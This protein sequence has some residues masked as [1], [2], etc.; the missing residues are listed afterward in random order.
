M[1]NQTHI[2]Y[3]KDTYS[4]YTEHVILKHNN[5]PNIE[6]IEIIYNQD[7]LTI[8]STGNS[9]FPLMWSLVL[10]TDYSYILE[11]MITY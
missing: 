1:N 2:T 7:L 5:W 10:R 4:L 9:G 6:L 3:I 8:F 11:I